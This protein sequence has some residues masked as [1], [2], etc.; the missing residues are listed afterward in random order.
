MILD[1]NKQLQRRITA[2]GSDNN[3]TGKDGEMRKGNM[4]E[5]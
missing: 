5:C 2:S 3:R 1:I 4:Y